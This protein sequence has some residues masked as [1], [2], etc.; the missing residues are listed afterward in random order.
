[1]SVVTDSLICLSETDTTQLISTLEE[2]VQVHQSLLVILQEEK[3]LI[4]EGKIEKL[5]PCI[6]KKETTL[7]RLS[8]LE[9]ER[10]MTI[11]RLDSENPSPTLKTLIPLVSLPYQKKL[12]DLRSRL[13]VLTT[14]VNEINQINGVL[15]ERVLGQISELFGML[16]HLTADGSTYQQ[17]GEMSGALSGRTISRR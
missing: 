16:Q 6:G 2:M 14:S 13:D 3:R 11:R 1:M 10:I 12:E 7:L 9:K 5:L 15:V 4:I 8:C 17:T